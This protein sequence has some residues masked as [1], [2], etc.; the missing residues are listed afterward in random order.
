[1]TA[2]RHRVL[3]LVAAASL[4]A[5][6]CGGGEA[7]RASPCDP[8]GFPPAGEPATPY[9]NSARTGAYAGGGAP[10]LTRVSWT[11][12]LSSRP[13]N[14]LGYDGR[15]YVV[16]EAGITV[17]DAKDGK[18]LSAWHGEIASLDAVA[19]QGWLVNTG[20]SVSLRDP[21]TG[22]ERWRFAVPFADEDV[23]FFALGAAISG[24]RVAVATPV[25][26]Y[27]LDLRTGKVLHKGDVVGEPDAPAA[28]GGVAFVTGEH[29]ETLAVDLRDGETVWLRDDV[30]AEFTPP[31]VLCDLVYVGTTLE[32]VALRTRTGRPKWRVRTD[33]LDFTPAVADGMVFA[34]T[35]DGM[36]AVDAVSG[37]SRWRVPLTGEPSAQPA[38]TRGTLYTALTVP[39]EANR[40][41]LRS[42]LVAIDTQTGRERSRMELPAAIVDG[43]TIVGDRVIV[44]L[45]DGTVLALSDA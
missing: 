42:A 4:V 11:T 23:S 45:A 15:L 21:A 38:V 14:L 28:A 30:G 22:L 9:G 36:L 29:G 13:A 32:V 35:A 27:V 12:K 7:R 6:G 31:S 8:R 43:P 39:D 44:L 17:L 16:S 3:A 20:D 1:M 18:G 41:Q 26:I 34:R 37:A 33:G 25:Q 10:G 5:A 19:P 24:D 40:R 2:R